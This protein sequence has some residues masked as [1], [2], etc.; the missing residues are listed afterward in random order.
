[1]GVATTD[2]LGTDYDTLFRAADQALYAVKRSG[3]GT[4]RFYDSSM[5]QMLSV[6]SPIDSSEEQPEQPPRTEKGACLQ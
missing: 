2:T 3:R 4:F 5:E 1:M 6:I